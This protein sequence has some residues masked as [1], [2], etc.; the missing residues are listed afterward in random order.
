MPAPSVLGLGFLIPG[1]Y[2]VAMLAGALLAAL[3]TLRG[4][5]ARIEPVAAGAIVGES[6]AALVAGALASMGFLG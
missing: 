2:A 5:S 6:V 3:A 1:H 4:R